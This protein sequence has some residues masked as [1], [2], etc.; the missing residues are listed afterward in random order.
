MAAGGATR[1]RNDDDDGCVDDGGNGAQE[2]WC[3]PRSKLSSPD[4]DSDPCSSR[5][6]AMFRHTRRRIV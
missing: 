4:W 1:E 6:A 5:E 3:T 2:E